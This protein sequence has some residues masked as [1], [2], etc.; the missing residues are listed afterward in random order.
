MAPLP[1][2]FQR[3]YGL[4]LR[5]YPRRFRA[6]FEGEMRESVKADEAEAR[7]AGL[8][9]TTRFYS[10][11]A[12]EAVVYGLAER[13]GPFAEGPRPSPWTIDWR[14][15]FRSLKA[16]PL[17]TAVAVLSLALGIGANAA[18]FS[19]LNSLTLK[20]LPVRAPEQLVVVDDGS[21]TNPI[22]EDIRSRHVLPEAFAWWAASMN[23]STAGETDN[24]QG[25]YASG[26][27][28]DVLGVHA[29]IGRTF[30]PA[31]DSRTG[32][33]NGPVAVI[34]DGFW[35]RRFGGSRSAIGQRL[36]VD[37]LSY[38]VIGVLPRG[39]FGPDVGRTPEIYAPIGDLA[40]TTGGPGRLDGRS[41]WWLE[42]MGRLAPGQTIDQATD[43][44]RR[45]EPA[46]RQATMPEDYPAREKASYLTD[47]FTLVS[48]ANGLSAV[49]KTYTTPLQI[50]LAVVGAVLIIACA[51][52]ANL[53]LARATAR[54]HELSLRLAL[55]ASRARVARQLLTE[56]AMLSAAGAIGGLAFAIW[57]GAL[58]V[59]Q[60]SGRE[61]VALDLTPDWRVLGFTAGLAI[62]TA[63]IFGLAPAVGV[64]RL[65]ANE[66]LKH[67]GR[68]VVGERR[69]G[70]RNLLVVGQV[71]LS[72]ALVVGAALFLRT[73][74]SLTTASLGFD[75]DPMIALNINA[76]KLPA[77]STSTR[78]AALLD[79]VRGVPGVS[80]AALSEITPASG[81]GWNTVVEPPPYGDEAVRR[82]LSWVNA[83][84]PGWFATY[85]MHLLQ[86]RDL[87]AHDVAGAV[88]VAIVNQTFATRF[89]ATGSVI[90]ATVH[91]GLQGP[92]TTTY[93]V[94]GLV[95]DSVYKSPRSGFEAQIFVPIAQMAPPKSLVLSV[96]AARDSPTAVAPA[97]ASAIR[98]SLPEAGF[99]VHLLADQ[100]GATTRQER[101]LAAL[102]GF[103]GGL[104]L[105][106]AAL[107]LYGVTSYA[108]NRRQA[109]IGI[110][111]ALGADRAGVLRLVVGRVVWLVAIGVAVGAGLSLWVSKFIATLLFHVTPRDPMTF[112]AASVVLFA[113][114]LVA[115]WLPA[116]R[117]ASIDPSKVLRES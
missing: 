1:S 108:V 19:I 110:R 42:I 4:L 106:L 112:V 86:G 59:H 21:W 81:S 79:T 49:R 24:V 69:A 50:I 75:P 85:G 48:A 51:N 17:V 109:E 44:L 102:A 107:G 98:Q 32:G 28:F 105:L 78:F 9:A 39:F 22:W 16:T 74:V 87:D 25:V 104:A 15:A 83:I 70:L 114:A 43:A 27:M 64:A 62:L 11:T 71:A 13:Q 18:L 56:S 45:M 31:D 89:L 92:Q 103:F 38:T 96:R 111:M 35:Q 55:G 113:A 36:T 100:V 68:G 14:D 73:F 37:G 20:T 117:A 101:L 94:V 90:G 91:A 72:L 116:R 3:L 65:D 33:A 34:S 99:S 52:I 29:V 93:T 30:T 6:R 46:I 61:T 88:P 5:A 82:R 58:L 40:L 8:G 57:G 77:A 2:F 7:E 115:G 26:E 23:L 76:T 53:L 10:R 63:V 80:N 47:P 41:N 97:V 60:L 84:T 66:A 67:Q 95:N 54:Q 12:A